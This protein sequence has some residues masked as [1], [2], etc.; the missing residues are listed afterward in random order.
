MT[1]VL[2]VLFQAAAVLSPPPPDP[3]VRGDQYCALMRTT[4]YVRT[5]AYMNRFTYDGTPILTE[6]RI[7]AATW[8]IPINS[9]IWVEGYGTYRVADRGKL[10][11]RHVDLAVWSLEEAYRVTGTRMVCV[12]EP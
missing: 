8:G 4:G 1:L 6:E 12:A 9:M 10:G 2:S 3:L 7:A 11:F 5:A